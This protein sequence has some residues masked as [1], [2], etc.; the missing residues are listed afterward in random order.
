MIK[1]FILTSS[2]L[3]NLIFSSA[4]AQNQALDMVGSLSLKK[5]NVVKLST[6]KV[7]IF[8]FASSMRLK[9]VKSKS[10]FIGVKKNDQIINL[11][12]DEHKL[13]M[14]AASELSSVEDSMPFAERKKIGL[15]VHPKLFKFNNEDDYVSV[16]FNSLPIEI[17]AAQ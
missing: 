17:G 9:E 2:I 13:S 7:F 3:S 5:L 1:K 12:V 6:G 15:S 8:Q 14:T 10:S 11:Y 16:E 4:F